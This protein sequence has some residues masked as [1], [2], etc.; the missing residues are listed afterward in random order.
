MN[1]IAHKPEFRDKTPQERAGDERRR[2]REIG[3]YYAATFATPAGQKV[4][5]DLR[6]KFSHER[7]RF[8]LSEESDNIRAAVVD[9]QCSVL[10]EIEEAIREGTRFHEPITPQTNGLTT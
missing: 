2:R 7:P 4:L 9:G 10:L 6:L 5:A 3:L 1:E 8:P